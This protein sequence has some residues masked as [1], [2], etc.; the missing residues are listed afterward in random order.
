MCCG[1]GCENLQPLCVK[2]SLLVVLNVFDFTDK[3]TEV[4]AVLFKKL[5]DGRVSCNAVVV[6]S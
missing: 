6:I 3:P 5:S 2:I 4:I 1:W